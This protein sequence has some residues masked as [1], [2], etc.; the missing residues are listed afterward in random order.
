[1]ITEISQRFA[2]TVDNPAIKKW[3]VITANEWLFPLLM[4]I[5]WKWKTTSVLLSSVLQLQPHSQPQWPFPTLLGT[6]KSDNLSFSDRFVSGLQSVLSHIVYDNILVRWVK[7]SLGNTCDGVSLSYMSTAPGIYMPQIVPTVIGF[8]FP[9]TIYPLT[10][11]VVEVE[12]P[13]YLTKYNTAI[14]TS[15]STTMVFSI[16]F[17]PC[18]IRQLVF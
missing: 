5:H 8:E 17:R 10:E 15:Y 13:F 6:A 14:S 2:Q 12:D 4:C 9:R 18:K 7:N 1:M 11:Y 16:P 3:D